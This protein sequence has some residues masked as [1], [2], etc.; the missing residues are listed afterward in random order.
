MKLTHSSS[1]L[2]SSASSFS[3][4]SLPAQTVDAIITHFSQGVMA[5]D[6]WLPAGNY[7]ISALPV[8][9]GYGSHALLRFQSEDGAYRAVFATRT[10]STGN[11]AAQT[12]VQLAAGGVALRVARVVING[13]TFS[14]ALPSRI[15]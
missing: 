9:E 15:C 3:V 12:H 11:G 2:S 1:T 13:A 6:E 14:L 5:G 7:T 4:C 8:T 10:K